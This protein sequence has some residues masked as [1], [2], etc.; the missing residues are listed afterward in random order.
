MILTISGSQGQGKSTV[1]NTLEQQG[2]TVIPNKTARSILLDWNVSLEDVYSDKP[3][4]KAFHDAILIKHEELCSPHYD[5]P[6]LVF[7]ERSYA[8]IFSYAISVLGPFNQYSEWVNEFHD[9]CVELQSNFASAIY[10]TGRV[11]SPLHDGVRSTNRYFSDSIDLL[12][13]HHLKTFSERA[14]THIVHEIRSPDHA[15]RI[16]EIEKIVETYFR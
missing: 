11:Y 16:N 15:F 13:R 9:S 8:D 2:Y 6:E 4:A 5:T 10:L 3:L 1:L 14:N 7:I 12:I